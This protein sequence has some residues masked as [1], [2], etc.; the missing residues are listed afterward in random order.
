MI[1]F[2]CSFFQVGDIGINGDELYEYDWNACN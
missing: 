2:E 1:N